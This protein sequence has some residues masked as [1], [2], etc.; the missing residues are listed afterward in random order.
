MGRISAVGLLALSAA[1]FL[2]AGSVVVHQKAT[3][4]ARGGS[5]EWLPEKGV[6][7]GS[8]GG[9]FLFRRGTPRP[10]YLD[11]FQ[12]RPT[13]ISPDGT[14]AITVTGPRKSL[15]AY[16]T[17]EARGKPVPGSPF[18]V[19]PLAAGGYV[20]WRPDSKAFALTDQLYAVLVF[21]ARFRVG[22]NLP[23]PGFRENDLTSVITAALYKR[24]DAYYG[25]SNWVLDT[26]YIEALRW[27]G[28]DR[29]LTSLSAAT[30]P[31]GSARD[32]VK[33]W[34]FAYL[35]GVAQRKVLRVL[36]AHQLLSRYGIKMTD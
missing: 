19:W 15:L 33:G 23:G 31:P 12:A 3:P 27:I 1:I 16:V 18:R 24:A 36:D 5:T 34:S 20:L 29:L 2:G 9:L 14:L 32:H 7:G 11:A 6:P 26:E 13:V 35:V 25:T 8:N 21:T 10:T 4:T 17:V 28:N 30:S 22:E